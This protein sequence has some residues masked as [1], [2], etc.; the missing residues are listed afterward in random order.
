MF[1]LLERQR[2]VLT[3][4]FWILRL[5][6]S[7]LHTWSYKL[8]EKLYP[9]ELDDDALIA[10]L[11]DLCI[12]HLLIWVLQC[13]TL[14]YP[15]YVSSKRMLCEATHPPPFESVCQSNQNVFLDIFF[16]CSRNRNK[17]WS[18]SGQRKGWLA[19]YMTAALLASLT[20]WHWPRFWSCCHWAS[21]VSTA[22]PLLVGA[23]VH[24][25]RA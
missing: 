6:A 7:L 14:G 21:S 3:T 8:N 9:S 25:Q 4:F 13:T 17:R 16:F 5:M 18:K 12:Y 1:F 11:N 22:G 23:A 10:H 2:G 15:R 20:C 19:L 24:A